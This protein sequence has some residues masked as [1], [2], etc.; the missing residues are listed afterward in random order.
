[1]GNFVSLISPSMFYKSVMTRQSPEAFSRQMGGKKGK[2]AKLHLARWWSIAKGA[3]FLV[4]RAC[5][6]EEPYK[7]P[8]VRVD[9]VIRIC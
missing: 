7:I 6:A 1:M 3:A 2:D 8:T 9:R 4:E 5:S